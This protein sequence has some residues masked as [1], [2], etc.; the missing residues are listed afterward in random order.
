MTWINQVTSKN[1]AKTCYSL[2]NTI[3]ICGQTNNVQRIE[4]HCWLQCSI[5]RDGRVLAVFRKGVGRYSTVIFL[6]SLLDKKVKW[7]KAYSFSSFQNFPQQNNDKSPNNQRVLY[8]FNHKNNMCR[9][10]ERKAG[11]NLIHHCS[12]A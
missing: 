1:K 8:R 11:T 4:R 10:E 3:K 9:Q 6:S 12:E 5:T 7:T 2:K